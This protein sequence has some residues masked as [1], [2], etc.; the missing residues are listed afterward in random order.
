MKI[1]KIYIL[2]S[3][4]L[5]P[6]SII[7]AIT[8]EQQQQFTYYW[9]AA[10]QAIEEERYPEAYVLLEFCRALNPSDG[11]TLTFLGILYDG[12][13][14]KELAQETFK[15]AYEADPQN[16]WERYLVPLGRKY[17][18]DKQYKKALAVQDEIEQRQ[19][20]YTAL[21]AINRYRIYAL[22][23][24]PKKAIEAIDRYL[25]TDPT[26]LQFLLFRVELL[27]KTNAKKKVLYAAYEEVLAIN[28]YNATVL[29]NY[30]YHLATHKGDL[31]K[32]EKMSEQTI[33]ME[34][35]SPTYLDTYGW[36]MHLK[37]QDELALFYLQRA[38]SNAKEPQQRKEIL[39][40]LTAI[41]K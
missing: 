2:L 26:N 22:W 40:H 23:D 21:D 25:V 30:A 37:G 19:G 15:K 29:N 39:K 16:Q 10:R 6:Y 28:P 34:P 7:H 33:R 5:A 35:Q 20:E 9:Y 1:R 24:K 14:Q 36:I 41:Q 18:E 32:A 17:I 38:L 12:I 11:Q 3:L 13:G 8:T 31:Q 27:E 4:F